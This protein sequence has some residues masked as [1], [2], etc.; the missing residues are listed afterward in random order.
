MVKR[1]GRHDNLELYYEMYP[2]HSLVAEAPPHHI[3]EENANKTK[4]IPVE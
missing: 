1:G 3:R 2:V 4:G